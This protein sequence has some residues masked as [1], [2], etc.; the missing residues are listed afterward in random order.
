M[1]K[2]RDEEKMRKTMKEPVELKNLSK[3]GSETSDGKDAKPGS[4]EIYT[5]DSKSSPFLFNPLNNQINQII[6]DNHDPLGEQHYQT[7]VTSHPKAAGSNKSEQ[8][9]QDGCSNDVSFKHSTNTS[10]GRNKNKR[11]KK[12]DRKVE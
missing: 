4:Q 2:Q 1:K 3:L 7:L 11:E 8:L 9:N 6:I 5:P 12:R 10:K